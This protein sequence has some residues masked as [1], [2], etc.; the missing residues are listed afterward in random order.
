MQKNSISL[1]ALLFSFV[2]IFCSGCD[3]SSSSGPMQKPT[4]RGSSNRPEKDSASVPL[5]H[6]DQKSDPPAAK[7]GESRKEAQKSSAAGGKGAPSMQ[8]EEKRKGGNSLPR[9]GAGIPS[10]SSGGD[11]GSQSDQGADGNRKSYPASGYGETGGMNRR[12]APPGWVSTDIRNQPNAT[13]LE[14]WNNILS[15]LNRLIVARHVK[16]SPLGAAH[17]SLTSAS[18]NSYKAVGRCIAIEKNGN[19]TAYD[20]ECVANANKYEAIILSVKFHP[21][22]M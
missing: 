2:L 3:D 4:D 14:I 11:S 5:P 1:F 18:N 12:K 10:S 16:F 15:A 21:G 22:N 20:F 19:Q 17:T 9:G 8:Q 13:D 7:N 6:F